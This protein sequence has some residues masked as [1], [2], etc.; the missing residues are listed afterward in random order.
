MNLQL[1]RVLSGLLLVAG[2]TAHGASLRDELQSGRNAYFAGEFKKAIQELEPIAMAD[3]K[4]AE[5]QFWLGKSYAMVADI[6][7]PLLNLHARAKAHSHLEAAAR[8]RP[9]NAEYRD[10][11]FNYLIDSE[12]SRAA[13]REAEALAHTVP[14]ESAEYAFMQ[15]RLEL[16]RKTDSRAEYVTSEIFLFGPRHVAGLASLGR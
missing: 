13:L 15:S 2:W 10:D 7:A 4:N 9:E 6:N 8:L 12:G 11:L 1:A 3:P 14:E 16:E 5:A